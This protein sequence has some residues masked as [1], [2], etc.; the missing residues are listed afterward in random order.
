[1]S[2]DWPDPAKGTSTPLETHQNNQVEKVAIIITTLA[3][4]WEEMKEEGGVG[5]GGVRVGVGE[6]EIAQNIEHMM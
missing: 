4:L 3:I 5:W 1:M 2:V 6:R